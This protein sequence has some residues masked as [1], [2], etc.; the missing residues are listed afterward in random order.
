MRIYVVV[1]RI[2][3]SLREEGVIHLKTKKGEINSCEL[4]ILAFTFQ[5]I[6]HAVL[7]K[8]WHYKGNIQGLSNI[9]IKY[10][11]IC[12]ALEFSFIG[13]NLLFFSFLGHIL[14]RKEGR[15][16]DKSCLQ[17]LYCNFLY[18]LLY[19]VGLA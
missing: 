9:E 17:N 14:L 7:F 5:D 13:L 3:V 11:S 4:K 1:S 19:I 16:K 12:L 6:L 10:W 15:K 8:C 2:A 18:E